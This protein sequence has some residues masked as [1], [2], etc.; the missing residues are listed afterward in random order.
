MDYLDNISR[1]NPLLGLARHHGLP[2]S[3]VRLFF[4]IMASGRVGSSLANPHEMD[5]YFKVWTANLRVPLW[6]DMVTLIHSGV[7]HHPNC[8]T[9]I[10]PMRRAG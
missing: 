9:M 2:S 1:S 5:A 8:G 7:L 6:T 3:V 10:E 4:E